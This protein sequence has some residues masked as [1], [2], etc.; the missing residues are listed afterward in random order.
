MSDI[1]SKPIAE[2]KDKMPLILGLLPKNAQ[3]RVLGAIA[4]VMVLVIL[5]SGRNTPKETGARSTPPA[6][7]T[8]DPNQA[9]IQ[10]YRTRLE[11]QARQL[12]AEEAQLHQTKEVLGVREPGP[13]ARAGRSGAGNAPPYA[14][15]S[16]P[17]KNWIEVDREKREYQG[18]YASNLALTYRRPPV[19]TAAA[20]VAV[21][22]PPA[23]PP[24]AAKTAK[25]RA[26]S[27]GTKEYR[28][29]EGTVIE[30]V[31]TNRLDGSFSGPVNALVTTNV[32]A[33]D[34]QTLLIPQGTRILGEVKKVD[35]VG[36]QRLAVV[37]HRLIMPNGFS[38]SLDQFHGLNQIG[39]TG[40][41]DLVNRHY[42]QIFGASLAIGAIAG[43]AQ[44]NTRYGVDESA[45][46]AY[47]QG[48][49]GSLSQSSMRILDRFLNVLPTFTIREGHRI[50]VYLAQDLKLPAYDQHPEAE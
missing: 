49:A 25:D 14:Y 2:V 33:A 6:A 39:E 32:Y 26:Q 10:E 24:E 4:L 23:D 7:A 16:E 8:I 21:A 18:L 29:F 48:V 11:E 46:D 3:A 30:A 35:S 47:R 50:K 43:L 12:A 27:S 45:A 38:V 28:V 34:H 15:R 13:I 20:S 5:F 9:R 41:T 19:E 36:Q 42:L 40:L 44:A 37:F 31:L 22:A 1:E 17:E